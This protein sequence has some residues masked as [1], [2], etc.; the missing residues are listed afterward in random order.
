M[1]RLNGKRIYELLDGVDDAFIEDA[2]ISARLPAKGIKKEREPSAFRRWLNTPAAAAII[3]GIV[4]FTVL[5]FI[6]RAGHNAPVG[7]D[8]AG[9]GTQPATDTA[10]TEP[11]SE[12]VSEPASEPVTEP[13]SEPVT[14][15]RDLPFIVGDK[16][17]NPLPQLEDP[18]VVL[19]LLMVVGIA[20]VMLVTF[21]RAGRRGGVTVRLPGADAPTLTQKI[22]LTVFAALFVLCTPY[23]VNIQFNTARFIEYRLIYAE[24]SPGTYTLVTKPGVQRLAVLALFLPSIL[25]CIAGAVLAVICAVRAWRKR[26]TAAGTMRLAGMAGV[27]AWFVSAWLT[28]TTYDIYSGIVTPTNQGFLLASYN[29]WYRWRLFGLIGPKDGINITFMTEYMLFTFMPTC[30]LTLLILLAAAVLLI[31]FFKGRQFVPTPVDSRR[32]SGLLCALNA[33]CAAVVGAASLFCIVDSLRMTPDTVSVADPGTDLRHAL[34]MLICTAVPLILSAVMYARVRRNRLPCV[35]GIVLTAVSLGVQLFFMAWLA[36]L[37]FSTFEFDMMFRVIYNNDVLMF[38]YLRKVCPV[39]VAATIALLIL[40]VRERRTEKPR[41]E[42]G[43]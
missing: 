43:A 20:V 3:S 35:A 21:C 4:A 12:P 31:P 9:Y 36:D 27:C 6:V 33:V 19:A 23:L 39:L 15:A 30:M 2:D 41:K 29:Y 5:F 26:L 38:P 14:E 10:V 11:A 32:A 18:I 8:P 28:V 25:A 24:T 16:P 42:E 13:V 1:T 22:L 37:D 34:M 40:F 7:P 17:D